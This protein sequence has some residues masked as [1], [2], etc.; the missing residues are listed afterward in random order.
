MRICA[1]Q[2]LVNLPAQ[3][4]QPPAPRVIDDFPQTVPYGTGRTTPTIMAKISSRLAPDEK[5]LAA[6][7]EEA[8]QA[9]ACRRH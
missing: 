6:I 9:V 1:N 4:A 7:N 5:V 8:R 3:S 2:A